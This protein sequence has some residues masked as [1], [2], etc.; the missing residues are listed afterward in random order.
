MEL[1]TLHLSQGVSVDIPLIQGEGGLIFLIF[2]SVKQNMP[3]QVAAATDS[4]TPTQAIGN[5][6]EI[7]TLEL[8][9]C[10]SFICFYTCMYDR[11]HVVCASLFECQFIEVS[12]F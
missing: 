11:F 3:P 2:D 8:K 7:W 12:V 5:Y 4:P 10:P 9:M 1:V 6:N